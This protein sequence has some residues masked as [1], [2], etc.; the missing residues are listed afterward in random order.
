MPETIE[1]YIPQ[2]AVERM[3][4]QAFFVWSFFAIFAAAWVFLILLAPIAE[5]YNLTD[6]SNPIY[7]F[8]SYLC[9]Q[10]PSR[11]FSIENH[12]FA[13]CSRCF[14]VYFGLLFG[15]VIYPFLRPIEKNEP[16]PR[17]WL[18]LAMIPIGVD[19]SL[20]V[21]DIWENTHFSRFVTGL[22]LGAA[23][24]IFIIPALIDIFRLLSSKRIKRLSR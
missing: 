3:Q 23:C 21:F 12:A 20:G 2:V 17:F 7:K 6:I 15:F 24:A 10:I 18:F 1:N 11:S 5:T 4:R 19:W 9:H 8:F 14:G 22:I 16:L 13:V